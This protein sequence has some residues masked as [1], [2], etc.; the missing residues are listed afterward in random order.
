M[1]I[2]IGINL[3]GGYLNRFIVVKTMSLDTST[4]ATKLGVPEVKPGMIT[5]VK[6]SVNDVLAAFASHNLVLEMY[7][8]RSGLRPGVYY[9]KADGR[10]FGAVPVAEYAPP[11]E[12]KGGSNHTPLR[13]PEGYKDGHRWV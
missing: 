9:F 13:K 2:L 3:S 11:R 5:E 1:I 4:L 10:I 7:D 8:S 12:N 6:S